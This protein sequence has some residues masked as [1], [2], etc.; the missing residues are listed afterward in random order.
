MKTTTSVVEFGDTLV[1]EVMTPRPDIVAVKSTATMA[2]LRRLF[3]EQQYSRIPVY[4][5]NLD[6]ILGFVFV[7]DLVTVT[8][9]APDEEIS[10]RLLRPAYAVPETKRVAELLKELQRQQLQSQGR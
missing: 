6:E 9:A 10:E 1:R 3:A 8:D 2:E 7:K 4:K 5:E